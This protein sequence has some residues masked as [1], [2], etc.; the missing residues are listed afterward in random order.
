M[1]REMSQSECNESDLNELLCCPFCGGEAN[2]D[3]DS[4]VD[5]SWSIDNATVECQACL[6]KSDIFWADKL[7][8]ESCENAISDAIDAWNKRAT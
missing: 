4:S 6:A 3:C 2:I 5:I 1:V 8:K 7:N